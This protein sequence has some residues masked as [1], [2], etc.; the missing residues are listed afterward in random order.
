MGFKWF[1]IKNLHFLKISHSPSLASVQRVYFLLIKEKKN[2]SRKLSAADRQRV[3]LLCAPIVFHAVLH[4]FETNFLQQ[5][6]Q[7]M[8]EI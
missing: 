4:V 5:T 7:H 1:N 8:D 6:S 2:I 3:V